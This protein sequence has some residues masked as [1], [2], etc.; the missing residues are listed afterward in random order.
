MSFYTVRRI[1]C[2]GGKRKVEDQ[3]SGPKAQDF[4]R[5]VSSDVRPPVGGVLGRAAPH[6]VCVGA[7]LG[8]V[9]ARLHGGPGV[10]AVHARRLRLRLLPGLPAVRVV[11][12]LVVAHVAALSLGAVPEGVF[13]LGGRRWRLLLLGRLLQR[14]GPAV[15]GASAS[16]KAVGRAGLGRVAPVAGRLAAGSLHHAP[17]VLVQDAL[18]VFLV[19][20]SDERA[21]RAVGDVHIAGV[22]VLRV[23][24][25]GQP[26]TG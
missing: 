26:V 24:T 20:V 2:C 16:L 14:R 22:V 10:A 11:H 19:S 3:R 6:P 8:S 23:S 13:A 5:S 7:V 1:Y 18:G 25:R 4:E 12:V 21:A 17:D 9:V 15:R